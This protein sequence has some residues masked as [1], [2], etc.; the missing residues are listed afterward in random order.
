MTPRFYRD[1]GSLAD[2]DQRTADFA[3]VRDTDAQGGNFSFANIADPHVTNNPQ[4]WAPQIQQINTTDRELGFIT[5]SGDLTNNATDAEFQ[6]YRSGTAESDVAVWPAVGNHEYFSGG[7]TTYAAR[8][9]NYR[10]HVGPE[11]YSFDY[12]DRHFL[13]LENN[14]QAPFAEQFDWVRRDLELNAAGKKV[15]VIT[16]Q[17]M[18]VP[19]GSPS[20]YDAYG[21]LLE[22]YEA[23]LI[24]VGHE[25]S[26]DV[27]P[28][29]D[30][31]ST[32]KHIQTVSSSYTIDNA[33]RGFRYVHMV[34]E[35]FSNPFRMYG[36][37]QS[38][39]ITSP[40]PGTSIP[41]AGFPGIQVNAYDTADEV[42]QV[43]YRIDGGAWIR[44]TRPAS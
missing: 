7:G 13:I 21:D 5:V 37:D 34:D 38:L 2:G 35:E 41:K 26:N 6:L 39:T 23:E 18:N 10:R 19:F 16:H 33:P 31:A 30:F 43:R 24:L 9:N 12:G 40:A 25:H 8:I 20:T 1:F 44:S 11:W 17:P 29:S 15:V 14:G 28:D 4:L 42:A 27:E 22:Q 32:A 36:V 3:L